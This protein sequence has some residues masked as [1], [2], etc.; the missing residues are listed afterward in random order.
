L[1]KRSCWSSLNIKSIVSHSGTKTRINVLRGDDISKTDSDI[2]LQ[3]VR[4]HKWEGEQRLDLKG[5]M[6]YQGYY[7]T[8]LLRARH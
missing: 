7:G 1:E 6:N 3:G 2:C 8:I 4:I 5:L